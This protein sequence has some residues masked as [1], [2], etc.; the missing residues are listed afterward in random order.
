MREMV[1]R[2]KLVVEYVWCMPGLIGFSKTSLLDGE[3]N[4][5]LEL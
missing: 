2:L 4:H 3:D 1:T 5:I